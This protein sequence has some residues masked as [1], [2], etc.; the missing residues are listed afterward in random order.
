MKF[1]SA[2]A[3]ILVLL[4]SAVAQQDVNAA[5][6]SYKVRTLRLEHVAEISGADLA[7]IQR[8]IQS[9]EYDHNYSG[10]IGDRI[11]DAFQQ[12]GY[13]KSIVLDPDSTIISQE[14]H[15]VLVDVT[16]DVELGAIY[17]LKD[18]SFSGAKA[19]PPS[20]L[21]QLIP[22]QPGDVFD[23]EQM[24]KGIEHLRDN[25]RTAGYINFT[26]VPST[27][28]DEDDRTI[29]IVF[30]LDEGSVYRFGDL[31]VEGQ[32]SVPGAREKL[33]AAWNAYRGKVYD[34]GVSLKLF[35]RE[36]QSPPGIKPEEVFQ[37]VQDN[38]AQTLNVKITLAKPPALMNA[39]Q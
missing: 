9:R 16:V 14:P 3:C 8:D 17:R 29:S 36:I 32:E 5:N 34:D 1:A 38:Q 21:R 19:F 24:R 10:E 31:I 22:L 26:P 35:L 39:K 6:A 27:N 23:V 33:L 4:A 13:F 7:R 2:F 11:R 30:D 37:I 15:V 20:E 28:I 25:Y 18:I 12:L